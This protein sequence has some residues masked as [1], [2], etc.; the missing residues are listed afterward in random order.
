MLNRYL[1]LKAMEIKIG[2]Y[3]HPILYLGGGLQGDRMNGVKT[4]ECPYTGLKFEQGYKLLSAPFVSFLLYK[5]E[6]NA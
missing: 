3:L 5:I 6:L 1:K 4:G 2:R